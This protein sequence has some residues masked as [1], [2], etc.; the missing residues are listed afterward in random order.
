MFSYGSSH[1]LFSNAVTTMPW[2]GNTKQNEKQ[3]NG[4]KN[5]K[6]VY[7]SVVFSL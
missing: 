4:F 3:K 2:R 7:K 6:K 1:R 5:V